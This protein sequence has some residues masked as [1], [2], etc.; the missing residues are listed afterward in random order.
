M[1]LQPKQ[2]RNVGDLVPRGDFHC[3]GSP[4]ARGSETATVAQDQK[5][6]FLR[7]GTLEPVLG[8]AFRGPRLNGK[9]E[10]RGPGY[11]GCERNVLEVLLLELLPL[12][13]I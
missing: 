5:N 4:R 6:L 11:A 8:A 1:D 13:L 9:M 7:H 12:Q 3:P 2:I 10:L